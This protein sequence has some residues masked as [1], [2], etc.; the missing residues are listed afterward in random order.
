MHPCL[1]GYSLIGR[2]ACQALA[3]SSPALA[4]AS[5]TGRTKARKRPRSTCFATF[6]SLGAVPLYQCNSIAQQLPIYTLA[7]CPIEAPTLRLGVLSEAGVRF[8]AL[9]VIMRRGKS[10][11]KTRRR[12]GEKILTFVRYCLSLQATGATSDRCQAQI[13]TYQA[14]IDIS[15]VLQD[16]CEYNQIASIC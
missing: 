2:S 14:R 4:S 1:V 6:H 5:P 11:A 8:N 7:I 12:K 3:E 16:N 13:D 9:Q 15:P 10:H